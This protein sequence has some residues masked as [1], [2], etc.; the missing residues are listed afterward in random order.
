M[1]ILSPLKSH[2]QG[3]GNNFFIGRQ[4]PPFPPFSLPSPSYLLSYPFPHFPFPSTSHPRPL[5]VGPT[6]LH[7][8]TA[9]CLQISRTTHALHLKLQLVGQKK[10]VKLTSNLVIHPNSAQCI[11]ITENVCPIRGIILT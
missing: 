2:I 6:V 11:K 4:A 10:Y 3:H 9:Y 1:A 7:Y 5:E 8:I